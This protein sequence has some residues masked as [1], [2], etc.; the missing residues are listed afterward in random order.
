[1]HLATSPWWWHATTCI[2]FHPLLSPPPPQ[3]SGGGGGG[4]GLLKYKLGVVNGVIPKGVSLRLQIVHLIY[5]SLLSW[6]SKAVSKHQ[7]GS[8]MD[9]PQLA[10]YTL[11]RKQNTNNECMA[12]SDERRGE[13]HGA[14]ERRGRDRKNSFIFFLPKKYL[15]LMPYGKFYHC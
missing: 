9:H 3:S 12:F 6:S 8:T 1:M 13:E 4:G 2:Y 14:R 11:S 5:S 15:S 10:Q 7:I